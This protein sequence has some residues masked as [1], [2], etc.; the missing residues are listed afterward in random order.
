MIWAVLGLMPSVL[1]ITGFLTWWRPKKRVP[2]TRGAAEE[3]D[4][5]AV[6]A[7]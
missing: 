5:M 7:Q 3:S 1:L 4:R 6:A 2:K